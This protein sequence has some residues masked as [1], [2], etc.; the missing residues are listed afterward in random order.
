[1]PT[2]R[3]WLCFFAGI[4]AVLVGFLLGLVEMYVLGAT[5]ISLATLTSLVAFLRPLRL[6]V[7]RVVSPPRLHV[8][9]V[10]RV[11]LA[12]RN[13]PAKTPVMRMTDHVQGTAGAQLLVSPLASNDITRAAYRLP[14][15]RRGIVT[16]GPVDFMAT[17]AF[18][19]AVRKF[20]APVL[21]QIVVYPEVV[22]IPPAPP[23]AA[24]ERRLSSKQQQYIGSSS[25]EFHALRI[26]VP[27]DD[28][29]R[30]NWAASAR[31]DDLVVRVDETPTQNH[32]T[33]LLDNRA[34]TSPAALDRGA[35]VAASLIT[36]MR[37]R[38]DPFR[39]VTLD[40]HDTGYVIGPAGL[41]QALSILAIVDHVGTG[42]ERT[43]V[44][45]AQGAVVIVTSPRQTVNRDQLTNFSRT[46]IL[47]LAPSAWDPSATPTPSAAEV[48]GKDIRLTLGSMNDLASLWVRAIA[49]LMSGGNVER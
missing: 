4:G 3:G 13:G 6:A 31:H 16:L 20:R 47:S 48:T 23:S 46:M 19:L 39:L 2:L 43:S 8:G 25:D 5:L 12:I 22:P 11:E 40:G 27:G 9:S 7:G 35:S 14:T 21:N 33:V 15:E 41:D 29:R 44:Q 18:G 26:Y 42:R 28:I 36:S 30:I 45:Q 17:D 38:S 37:R 49:T 34:L 1:M 10:T 24:S 32:L